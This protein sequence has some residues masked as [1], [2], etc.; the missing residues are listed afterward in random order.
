MYNTCIDVLYFVVFIQ[1]LRLARSVHR[2]L[3]IDRLAD[4]VAL[5]CYV[6]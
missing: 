1:R 3:E 5:I 2:E 6:M 4:A